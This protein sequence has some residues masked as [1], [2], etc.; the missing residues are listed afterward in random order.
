MP[1]ERAAD[2]PTFELGGNTITSLAA[3]ARGADEAA[4]FRIDVPGG[5][6]LPAHHHD[7]LDVFTVE[8][9]G[10]TFHIG[11]E[12]FELTAGDSVVVPIGEVHYLVA[13]PAGRIDGRDDARRNHARSRRRRRRARPTLGE[14]IVAGF[15]V[16]DVTLFD[17]AKVR[18]RHGVL[19]QEGRI[20]WVGPHARAPREATAARAVDGAG[21]TL[22]PGLIDCHVHLCFDGIGDFAA[23]AARLHASP[24]LAP[25]KA[26]RNAAKHLARGVTTVRDLGG[27]GTCELASAIEDGVVPGPRVVAAGRALTVTGGH[28]HN[29]A[30]ARQVDGADAVRK[31]VREEIRAGAAAI[32]V[33]ATGGVLT[34]GIGATFTAFTPEELDAAVDEAHKWN[35]GVAAHAIGAEG[36]TQSVTAGV[37]SVEHCVQLTTA[38]AR[39]MAERGTFRGPTL[40]AAF[41]MIENPEGT[42]AYALEKISSV[43]DDAE[44]SNGVALRAK[45]RHVCSTDAGTPFNEHGNAP[46]E[47]Q[48]M[49]AWGMSP[50]DAMVAGTANGAELLRVPDIGSVAE[51]MRADLTLYDANPAEDIEALDAPRTVWKDGLVVAGR[52][53]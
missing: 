18:R 19:V 53:S 1:V 38:S 42:P 22:T 39:R 50:L 35:R 23:D 34:P 43:I 21:R 41:G 20:A 51:G 12:I 44:R 33:V 40:C 32:K 31:A 11:E 15:Y 47:L 14:L 10:G 28:G 7:H 25:I 4:L 17:G 6:G 2:H 49:V 8:R 37:D 36:V 3:P 52:R 46:L 9:G 48:R 5:G 45:V 30:F 26:V 27:I 16:A 24:M 29:V 13:G